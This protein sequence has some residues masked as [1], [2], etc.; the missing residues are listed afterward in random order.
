MKTARK[1]LMT[2]LAATGSLFIAANA[3]AL[4][5]GWSDYLPA[6]TA[7]ASSCAV[8]ESAT[9][10]YEFVGA[11]FR[12]KGTN[13]SPLNL[14]RPSIDSIVVG[15]SYQ[16]LTVRCNV[17][18]VYDYVPAVPAAEGD[19]FGT[20]ASW[21][22]ADWNTLIVGYKDPD[23]ISSKSQ[24]MVSL[25]KLSRA[26][27]TESTIASFDSNVSANAVANEDIKQFTHAFDFQNNEYYVEI[28]LIRQDIG[29]ATPVA[30]SVRLAN[31][32]FL[33]IP[34]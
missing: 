22:S 6:W 1:S 10:K 11:Q 27:L 18:P 13:V 4:P 17:T 9:G 29:V 12:Y 34:Q 15:P 32:S 3:S 33:Q 24:V 25:R 5:Q 28:N 20:P 26:T 23:G 2:S 8:D 7:T 16:P 21:K 31:G 14:S 19:L 30:Y